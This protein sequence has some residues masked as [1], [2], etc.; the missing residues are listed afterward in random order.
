MKRAVLWTALVASIITAITWASLWFYMQI[1]Q[2]SPLPIKD[3]RA[4]L[5]S[6]AS[7]PLM[8]HIDNQII[9]VKPAI[10]EKWLEPYTRAYTGRED[11]R[12]SDRLSD[13][14]QTLSRQT[15]T[16]ARDVRFIVSEEG[17]KII[18]HA[19][20]GDKLSIAQADQAVR[21]ALLTNITDVIL[22]VDTVEQAI[23]EELLSGLNITDKLA[24]GESN[25]SGSTTSRI[26]N[27]SVSAGLYNGL[28]IPA[29][30]TFSFNTILGE[31]DA[32]HG[33][34]PEKVIKGDTIAYEY[35]GGIC[36]VSTTMFRAAINAGLPIVERKPHAF[37]VHYY[38]PPGFDATIYPGVSDLRFVNNMPSYVLIQTRISG[39][40]LYVDFYGTTDGRKVSIDGPYQYEIQPDGAMKAYF[41]RTINFADGASTS[42]SFY[43][44]YKSPTL[45]PTEPNPYL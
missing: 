25:F 11:L 15:G 29:G 8:L 37:P 36:Q 2:D 32:E 39:K 6:S 34:M 38:Q 7:H 19:K 27:I 16:P 3:L 20:P 14:I 24:T 31:V 30:D 26:Q 18:S 5:L 40:N 42:K 22:P 28:L 10:I 41:T 4:A 44:N 21:Q 43:S 12:I 33:Y 17:I 45:Y 1:N 9:T 23:T 35:G 13:Y